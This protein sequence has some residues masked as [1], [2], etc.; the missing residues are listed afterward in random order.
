MG[1]GLVGFGGDFA[2]N[3]LAQDHPSAHPVRVRVAS[4]VVDVK[5]ADPVVRVD[6]RVRDSGPCRYEAERSV[7]L[8]ASASGRLRLDAGAGEL[9]VVGVEGLGEVR[10]VGR[11]CAS[12]ED[13]LDALQ[14]SLEDRGG[15][16][17]LE[18]HYPD[19]SSMGW[20]GEH[21]ARIDLTVEVPR[22]M[23]VDVD[24]SSGDLSVSGTGELNIDD[25]SGSLTV[26]DVIGSVRVDD[27]SGDI[28]VSGVKGD[29]EIEDGSGGIDVR[30]VQGSVRLDDGSGGIDVS[31]VG[32]DVLVSDDGSGSIV[33]RDVQGD[34][35]VRSDG[36]GSVR[37]SGVQGSVNIP[38][39][40]RE[41]RHS[42]G[43]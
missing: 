28:E 41:G 32:R 16:L 31:G 33:V 37:Y 20:R 15:E 19:H 7:K 11:A 6:V 13:D 21:Y 5:A 27:S 26:Q 34:F 3:L 35:T 25:S 29:V 38:R 9:K 40:K 36:S 14:V 18:T 2:M 24:D 10:A 4:P 12:N 39:D 22:G 23:S 30:D 8:D 17:A 43:G 42:H 1:Y